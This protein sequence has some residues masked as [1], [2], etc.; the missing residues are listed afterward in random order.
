MLLPCSH[1]REVM[2]TTYMPSCSWSGSLTVCFPLRCHFCNNQNFAEQFEQVLE[3]AKPETACYPPVG[4][5]TCLVSLLS[6]RGLEP[7]S[8]KSLA[9]AVYTMLTVHIKLKFTC[10]YGLQCYPY[11]ADESQKLEKIK[12]CEHPQQGM[13]TRTTSAF[14]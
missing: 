1:I 8:P 9:S 5:P 12:L 2:A 13:K 7:N 4:Q 10:L 11:F 14:P 6:K 3:L